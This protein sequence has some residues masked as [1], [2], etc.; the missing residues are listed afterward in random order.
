[1]KIRK[2]FPP[3]LYFPISLFSYFF[4]SLFLS[5][6]E[7]E[8]TVDLPIPEPKLVVDGRIEPG[9]KTYVYL[10]KSVPFFAPTDLN[11]FA[12]Q[13]VKNAVVTVTD[14]TTT[15]TL[16]EAI[17]GVG[18]YYISTDTTFAQYGKT[19]TLNISAE[20]KNYSS[21]TTIPDPVP[22]DSVWFEL[23]PPSDSLGYLWA[24]LTD[25][26]VEKNAYRWLA[27]RI[28]KDN[29]FVAPHF[30]VFDDKFVNGTSF[31]FAYDRGN[32]EN[33]TAEDDNNEERCYFKKNDSVH[34]KFCTIGKTEFEFLRRFEIEISNNGNPFAAPSSI[35]TNIT[36]DSPA[37]GIWCGYGSTIHKLKLIPVN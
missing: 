21:T 22:L 16:L 18:Y 19:Y 25:K 28:G 9:Q 37:L 32:T 8:I 15:I 24:N 34:V 10:S 6:C 1:M 27:K 11:S 36:G 35:P 7:K 30:S 12:A 3:F 4:V 5:G 26:P 14:G 20:G 33:S 29:D 23:F 13:T 17:P 31:P 2:S